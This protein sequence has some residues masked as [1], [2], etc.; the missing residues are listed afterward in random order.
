MIPDT[1]SERL[2]ELIYWDHLQNNNY[3]TN[4]ENKF[5]LDL[6]IFSDKFKSSLGYFWYLSLVVELVN[7]AEDMRSSKQCK[8]S[9][10]IIAKHQKR[11]SY[12]VLR[13]Y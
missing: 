5:S 9:D 3:S 11:L 10:P 7:A 2:T 4:Q 12:T 6:H 1:C 13:Q 8:N